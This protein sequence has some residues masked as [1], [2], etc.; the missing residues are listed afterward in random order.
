M[1]FNSNFFTEFDDDFF[2]ELAVDLNESTEFQTI[3]NTPQ[4]G[5]SI[6]ADDTID[7]STLRDYIRSKKT[8]TLL[9]KRMLLPRD[10]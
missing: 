1:D 10:L 7:N 3:C 6:N 4:Q 8:Q 9:E 5:P 2:K